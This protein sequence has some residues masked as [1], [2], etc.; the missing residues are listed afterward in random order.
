MR[1]KVWICWPRREENRPPVPRNC[2]SPLRCSLAAMLPAVLGLMCWSQTS[3]KPLPVL[4]QAEQVRHLTP[5]QAARG[6][7]VHIRGVITDDVPSPDFFMQDSTAGIYVEGN[8]STT[9]P[10]HFGDSVELEGVTGPGRFAPVVLER[11]LLALGLGRMQAG[12]K[13]YIVKSVLREE[14]MRAIREVHDGRRYLDR[15]VASLLAER[16]LHRSLTA[17]EVCSKS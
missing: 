11:K 9:F 5:E 7:P 13:G 10:H 12:A 1:D 3:A 17:R 8:K 16:L 2:F 15:T 6:Y 14:L 4:T